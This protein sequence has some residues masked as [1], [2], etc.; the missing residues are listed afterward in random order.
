M[1]M[2]TKKK[3]QTSENFNKKHNIHLQGDIIHHIKIDNFFGTYSKC[4]GIHIRAVVLN[5]FACSKMRSYL[6]FA[7]WDLKCS[8]IWRKKSKSIDGENKECMPLQCDDYE[9]LREIDGWGAKLERRWATLCVQRW[10]RTTNNGEW[11]MS[12]IKDGEEP[13]TTENG[14]GTKR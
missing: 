1:G 8:S 13:K 11:F 14:S 7:I 10:W 3:K 4:G 9:R 6:L 5:S 12:F 2:R